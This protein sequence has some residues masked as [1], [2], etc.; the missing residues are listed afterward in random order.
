MNGLDEAVSLCHGHP[1]LRS[2]PGA[3]RRLHR[4]GR[5]GRPHGRPPRRFRSPRHGLQPHRRQGRSLGP[6]ARWQERARR[7]RWPPQGAELVFAC[8]GNDDDLRAV[9]TG[10]DGAFAAMQK[11]AIFIDH[12]TASA[13]VARELAAEATRARLRVRRRAGL[14]RQPRRHQRRA[15]RHVRRRPGRVRH[16]A[17]GG[18]GLR[19]GDDAARA[20][21]L[22]PTRQDGQPDRDRRA[23]PRACRRRSPSARRPAST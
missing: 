2:R 5:H 8:V 12:T 21:R 7:R 23:S 16:G 20:E 15:H 13:S 14:R 10:A 19:Q 18:D 3:P 6:G 1:H 9:T 22:R 17:P 11:G 4:P